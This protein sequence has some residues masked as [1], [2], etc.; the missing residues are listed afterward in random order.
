MNKPLP[1]VKADIYPTRIYLDGM[2]VESSEL[3][4][5]VHGL[6]R[7]FKFQVGFV[8]RFCTP[9]RVAEVKAILGL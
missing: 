6:Y 2:R 8:C 7:G 5:T 1:I 4:E 3:K 9:E